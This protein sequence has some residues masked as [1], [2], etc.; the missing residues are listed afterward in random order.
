M[1]SLP[2]LLIDYPKLK[3]IESPNGRRYQMGDHEPVP[4]VT[5]IISKTKSQADKQV[6]EDWRNRIGHE[7]AQMQTR[8][9]C[10]I[11]N[12]L[13]SAIEYN[14]TGR[15]FEFK[16]NMAG[17]MAR[18]MFEKILVETL[19][20]ISLVVGVE[21]NLIYPGL[22]AGSCDLVAIY[23]DCLTI[24]DWKN[25][26]QIKPEAW[27]EDYI[28]QLGAYALAHNHMFGEKIKKTVIC[29]VSHPDTSGRCQHK[30]WH[31][32]GNKLEEYKNKW[33]NRLEQYYEMQAQLPTVG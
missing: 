5:T 6:L 17:H 7:Q 1:I 31:Y 14:L 19:S 24:L 15:T 10:D 20:K 32:E 13:H 18:C 33:L 4:S 28:I 8:Q 22:Y 30:E 12:Q 9:S 26:K 29:M 27:I 23:E 25:S 21:A 11:G 2:N 3:R 16:K